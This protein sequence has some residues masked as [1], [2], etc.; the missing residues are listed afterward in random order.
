MAFVV[1][2]AGRQW[3]AAQ[4]SPTNTAE[5][6]KNSGHVAAG[7]DIPS[8]FTKADYSGYSGVGPSYGASIIDGANNAYKIT[9]VMDYTHTGGATANTIYGFY[10]QDQ[11]IVN[12]VIQAEIK[13]SAITMSNIGDRISA[14]FKYWCSDQTYGMTMMYG[15]SFIQQ[16][17]AYVCPMSSLVCYL[18]SST[19]TPSE[20]DT[21]ATVEPHFL[22]P[23]GAIG[24]GFPAVAVLDGRVA[25]K[26]SNTMTWTQTSL[27]DP[28]VHIYGY[29]IIS[30]SVLL[31]S[32]S[33][34]L[35]D[36]SHVG[37]SISFS[38]KNTLW[39]LV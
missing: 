12:S 37:D 26:T 14:R 27:K 31:G 13:P 24:I 7:D 20:S 8:V 18:W 32:E 29:S 30:G 38:I 3:M 33:V 10:Q 2:G 5:L 35:G 9:P 21:Y 19:H 39:S 25:T 34:D 6:Y 22:N 16:L 36:Y 28:A 11:L 23:S 17:S 15:D 1:C 4:Y